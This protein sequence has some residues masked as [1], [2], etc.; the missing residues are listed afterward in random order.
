MGLILPGISWR[1]GFLSLIVLV[2]GSLIIAGASGRVVRVVDGDTVSVKALDGEMTCRLYGI[3]APEIAR[4]NRP[5]QP[6]GKEAA[7]ALSD[8]LLGKNVEITMTGERTYGREVCRLKVGA[9]DINLEMVRKGLAW[10]Y[11]EYLDTPYASAYI[12]A[13]SE[14]RA[15]R[16]G[17]WKDPNPIPPWEFRALHR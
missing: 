17:L 16:R 15:H 7:R 8:M 2:V 3:D 14:A 12:E 6:Y 5:G 13:E 11:R 9:T 10:A 4:G 1:R